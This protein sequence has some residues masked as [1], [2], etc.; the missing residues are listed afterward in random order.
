MQD[1]FI[2]LSDEELDWLDHF[3]LYRIDEGVDCEGRDEGVL[4]VS[5][6]DGLLTAVVSGPALIAPSQW[7]SAVWGDF[8]PA[9]RDDGE[10]AKVIALLMRH[11][12]EITGYLMEQ[13]DDFVP[14][15]EERVDEDKT[16]TIVD[17]WC[18]GYARGIALAVDEWE[19][20]SKEMKELLWPILAFTEAWGFFA[21]ENCSDQEFDYLQ[22]TIEVS[23]REIHAHWLAKRSNPAPAESLSGDVPKTGRNDLCPCGSGKKFKK[24]CLH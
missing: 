13:P 9:W 2:P 18:E 21:H 5:E 10:M 15:F 22:D 8:P 4:G 7:L 12:N 20:D 11:S 19:L 24:C 23:A 1:I 17:E 3:L 14:I 16:H 6:L